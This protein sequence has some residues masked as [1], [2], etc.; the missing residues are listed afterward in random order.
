MFHMERSSEPSLS[1]TFSFA[2]GP[3]FLRHYEWGFG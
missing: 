3:E 1:V 2:P